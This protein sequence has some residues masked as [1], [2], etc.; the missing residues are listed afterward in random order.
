M[1][2]PVLHFMFLALLGSFLTPLAVAY[3]SPSPADSV[4]FSCQIIDPEEWE[5]DQPL[6]AAK[7]L[8]IWTSANLAPCG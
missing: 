3:A 1:K 7:R 2:T 5:R 4:H 6:P 8:R